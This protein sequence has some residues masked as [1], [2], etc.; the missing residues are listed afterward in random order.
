MIATD[1]DAQNGEFI[2]IK[3]DG[4]VYWSPLSKTTDRLSFIGIASSE[5][6]NPFIFRL[7]TPSSSPFYPKFIFSDDY[8]HLTVD[9]N[10]VIPGQCVNRET[11][12][13]R[14]H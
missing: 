6:D 12:Y 8:S 7:T 10:A 5:K 11:E 1:F 4:Y 14:R 9:W 13:I 2:V 3:K